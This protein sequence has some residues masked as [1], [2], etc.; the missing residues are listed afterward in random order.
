MTSSFG[1]GSGPI[2]FNYIRC[3]GNEAK[4]V[5]CPTVKSR[6]CGHNEDVGMRCLPR[7]GKWI[8]T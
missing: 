1:Q 6:A 2:A 4:L 8:M 3:A 5:D 7:T